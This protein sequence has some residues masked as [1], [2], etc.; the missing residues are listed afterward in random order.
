MGQTWSQNLKFF[1]LT[2]ISYRGRWPCAYFH[3]KVYFFTIFFV[4]ILG[5]IW[6]QNLKFFRLTE[7]SYRDRLP[8]TY[9]DFNV[10]FFKIISTYIFGANLI[11]KLNSFKLT[12]IWY[13]G[14]WPCA[15]FHFNV[16]FLKF[17]FHSYFFSKIGPTI[18]S[19]SDWLKFGTEID[20]LILISILMFFFQNFCHSY[21]HWENLVPQKQ[22]FAKLN[23]V[24]SRGTLYM[25]ILNLTFII[26]K[27]FSFIFFWQISS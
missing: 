16:Y 21:F 6:S 1:K 20:H 13:R 2:E 27:F 12:D 26:S 10:S 11:P 14:T 25:L 19:F 4:H 18:W 7:I 15:Y 17:S 3:F 22:T 24:W 23:K 8:Y 5:R 9:F